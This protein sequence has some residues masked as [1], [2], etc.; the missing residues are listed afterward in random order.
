MKLLSALKENPERAYTYGKC[1]TVSK[2]GKKLLPYFTVPFSPRLFASF[3]FIAQPAT[4]VTRSAWEQVKGLNAEMQMA[5]DYDLWWR[6]YRKFGKP[7][8][9]REL[10]AATRMHRET[11]TTNQVELHYQE[12]MDLVKQN[13]GTVP[14]KW[15]VSLPIMKMIRALNKSSHISKA[16]L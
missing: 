2:T 11:K 9:C 16:M 1:R 14:F 7:E 12:S 5:F 6:L 10:V 3:C 15:R 13:W 8:Y 4:L